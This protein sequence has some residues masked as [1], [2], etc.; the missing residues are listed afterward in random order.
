MT[1]QIIYDLTRLAS[2]IINATPNG[3]DRV[4]MTL[5][6]HFF[7]LERNDVVGCI[8][9][10]V[11]GFRLLPANASRVLLE[12]IRNHLG[13][14]SDPSGEP[15]YMAIRDWLVTS[16]DRRSLVRRII[17][18]AKP[19]LS[20]AITFMRRYVMQILELSRQEFPENGRYLNVSQY[21]L[22]VPGAF[23]RFAA[24]PDLRPIFFIHDFLPLQRPEF[25]EPW[26]GVKHQVR[27]SNLSQFAAG[28]IVA[29]EK[30]RRDLEFYMGRR[31]RDN[32]P[33]FKLRVPVAKTF[34]QAS[35]GDDELA[36]VQ[37]YFIICGT[38][39]PRKN[40]FL[41]VQLW[42]ELI[43]IYKTDAPRLVIVGSRGWENETVFNLL[44]RSLDLPGHVIEV[45]GLS[46]PALKRLMRGSR[47]L[48][49][50]TFDEGLGLPL[51]EALSCGT[52]VI[53]SNL[54][55][56]DEIAG[57]MFR[58]VHPYDGISWLNAIV[59]HMER[60][61]KVETNFNNF[62]S[63]PDSENTLIALRRF[64]QTI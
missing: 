42:R 26:H 28:A 56:F 22:S 31:G 50:P 20:V 8:Y 39:E 34:V 14:N 60:K 30:I 64:L 16:F 2:R 63:D 45:T 40:H 62:Y 24:R 10:R 36:G 32:L 53:A 17:N 38:I 19:N 59:D 37:P 46:T 15:A 33:S 23:D 44:E 9:T 5:A 49:M 7:E 48:L 57:G 61:P 51:L 27:L 25:F 11:S 3:I 4:D 41:L 54:S 58:S 1:K 52:P 43:R 13:E 18:P 29:S 35:A 55:V 47:A 12:T 6:S 21:P